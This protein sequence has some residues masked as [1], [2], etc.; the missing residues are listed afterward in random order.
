MVWLTDIQYLHVL[1]VQ[2]SR[3]IVRPSQA[4]HD[5]MCECGVMFAIF[6]TLVDN[7]TCTKTGI[8]SRRC[9]WYPAP[10]GAEKRRQ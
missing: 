8:N 5:A 3:T 6:S 9:N 1:A 7:G 2:R 4:F 10:T